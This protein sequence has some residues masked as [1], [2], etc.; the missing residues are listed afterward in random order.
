MTAC[1]TLCFQVYCNFARAHLRSCMTAPPAEGDKPVCVLGAPSGAAVSELAADGAACDRWVPKPATPLCGKDAL[2]PASVR[3]PALDMANSLSRPKRPYAYVQNA[4]VPCHSC[5]HYCPCWHK[6]SQSVSKRSIRAC[7]SSLQVLESGVG[8]GRRVQ[9]K[10]EASA[11]FDARCEAN[12][13]CALVPSSQCHH[14]SFF[15]QHDRHTSTVVAAPSQP[16]PRQHE[17]LPGSKQ[18]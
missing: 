11:T 1:N 14:C 15:G 18:T 7:Y 6:A 13:F 17:S 16:C 9:S 10:V 12:L 3:G 2:A 4:E 5:A 8:A